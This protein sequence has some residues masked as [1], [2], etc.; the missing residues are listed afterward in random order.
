M[1]VCIHL[2]IYTGTTHVHILGCIDVYI[3]TYLNTISRVGICGHECMNSQCM[4]VARMC[5]HEY[6]CFSITC[7][8]Y[9]MFQFSN[10]L[11]GI[12]CYFIVLISFFWLLVSWNIFPYTW[13]AVCFPLLWVKNSHSS[14]FFPIGFPVLHVDLQELLVLRWCRRR[15][16]PQQWA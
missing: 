12:K 3:C 2:H 14:P 11:M 1:H 6:S 13:R 16:Q 15:E 7:L 9:L 8:A 4:L 5:L 10:N